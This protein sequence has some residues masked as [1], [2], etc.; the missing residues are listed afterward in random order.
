MCPGPRLRQRPSRSLVPVIAVTVAS[1]IFVVLLV[2]VLLRWPPLE[3]ADHDV[4]DRLNALVTGHPALIT[5][6]KAVTSLGSTP[7]LSGIVAAAAVFLAIQRRWRL[8]L[9]LLASVPGSFVLDPVLK[10]LAGRLRPVV[11]HPIAHG[12]GRSFPSG[13][14]LN[15]IVCYGA[16]LL[17]FLPAVKGNWRTAFKIV[18]ISLITLIGISRILL[19]VHFVSDVLGGWAIGIAWLGITSFA[20]ELSR[21]A[22]GRPV[23]APATEGLAPEERPDLRPAEPEPSVGRRWARVTAALAA[24]WVLILGAVTGLG[25][26]VVRYGGGNVL[27]DRTVSRWLAAHRTPGLTQV[28]LIFTRLGATTA[29]LIVA[30]AACVITLAVTRRW[31]PVSYL[32]LVMLGELAA[33][34]GTA[35]VVRRPRP[36]VPHLDA[37]APPT[38]AYPSGHTAATCCLYA[39]IAILVIGHARGRWRWLCL[40]RRFAAAYGQRGQLVA[41]VTVNMPRWLEAYR[42]LIEACAPFPPQLNAADGPA[43]LQPIPAG[44][45]A[46][47]QPT[48]SSV[49]ASTGPGP[50]SSPESQVPAPPSA[51]PDP[52]LPPSPTPLD[53]HHA[54]APAGWSRHHVLPLARRRSALEEDGHDPDNHCRAGP[55]RPSS[56]PS[57]P[58]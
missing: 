21:E 55:V 52:R 34:L 14:A 32:V 13:H 58:S 31:R 53:D 44:F 24:A 35:Y 39:A 10:D 15:S 17:V 57:Q 40:I 23:T 2:L 27:G 11:A 25:E 12:I 42:A 38:S 4:A 48:H 1:L 9:F 3:S 47:G 22:A 19:G 46:R 56:R 37:H 18:I 30:A 29:I 28:S 41:A 7:V 50:S 5:V 49:A 16:V 45:P 36:F 43:E 8:L 54:T 6:I 26:L 51:A 33:F 20:F